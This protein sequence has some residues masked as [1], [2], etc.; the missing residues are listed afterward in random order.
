MQ[1]NEFEHS[2]YLP[3]L[4]KECLASKNIKRIN[5]KYF[6]LKL[7]SVEL[8]TKSN[9][10]TMTNLSTKQEFTLKFKKTDVLRFT[11]TMLKHET[12]P[13]TLYVPNSPEYSVR[14]RFTRTLAQNVPELTIKRTDK[15]EIS[16]SEANFKLTIHGYLKIDK[17]FVFHPEII[18]TRYVL[19]VTN[20]KSLKWEVDE[21]DKPFN[22]IKAEIELP[23]EDTLPPPTPKH[24]QAIDVSEQ[25]EF[26]NSNLHL[27]SEPPMP[28]ENN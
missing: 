18:K 23:S 22:F 25:R 7:F 4:P 13:N 19:D 20:S 12:K 27:L 8:N 16:R 28:H 26:R 1:N 2:Y 11:K 15:Y 9:L 10:L 21:F 3:L 17:M 6:D 14:V 24:W 5:Q